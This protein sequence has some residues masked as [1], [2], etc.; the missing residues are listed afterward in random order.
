MTSNNDQDAER[1]RALELYRRRLR[2]NWEM[3]EKMKETK[4]EHETLSNKPIKLKIILIWYKI[5]VNLLE[6]Y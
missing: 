2:E 4:N 3:E 5:Q 1:N 6:K